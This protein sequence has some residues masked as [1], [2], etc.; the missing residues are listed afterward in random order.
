MARKE[1]QPRQLPSGRWN[2]VQT[3]TFADGSKKRKSYT[4]DTR[5]EAEYMALE[6]ALKL[7]REAET[8]KDPTVEELL[9]SYIAQR[10]GVLSPSTIVGYKRM[11]GNC[12]VS[13][14]EIR[15][16]HLT[17]TAIG[18]ALKADL[19]RLSPK[20][21]RNAYGFLFSAL[22]AHDAAFSTGV[23]LPKDERKIYPVITQE[24]IGIILREI[25]GDPIELPVLLALMLG[26]RTSEIFGLRWEDVHDGYITV[27]RALVE[28]ETGTAEKSTK[29]KSGTRSLILPGRIQALIGAQPHVGEHI[30]IRTQASLKRRWYTFLSHSG[31][32]RYRFHDLRAAN[33]SVMAALGVPEKYAMQRGGWATLSIMRNVYQHTFSDEEVQIAER[34]E[35]FFNAEC[36]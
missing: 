32:P 34:L 17:D 20:S 13:I 24:H 25:T 18:K 10:E 33:A 14:K 1:A 15:Y 9:G 35:A 23:V 12:F 8:A 31:L 5:K 29:S 30:V 11:C 22:K 6:D 4:A 2:V 21:V 28:S 7:R 3:V 16:S 27:Q 19:S 26:L 36:K